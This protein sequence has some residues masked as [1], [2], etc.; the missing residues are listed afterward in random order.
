M[1]TDAL[2]VLAETETI[3]SLDLDGESVLFD[4][5]LLSIGAS[6]HDTLSFMQTL[7]GQRSLEFNKRYF[8]LV[9]ADVESEIINTPL[10]RRKL[11]YWSATVSPLI[12]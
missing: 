11:R 3:F 6:D 7:S 1:T 9:Q 5:N 10:C 4:F 2:G 8:V 12:G